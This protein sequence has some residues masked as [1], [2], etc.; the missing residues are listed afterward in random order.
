MVECLQQRL[1]DHSHI[2]DHAVHRCNRKRKAISR[3]EDWFLVFLHILAI[4]KGESLHN[5]H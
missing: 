2:A 1:W 5:N 4:G 3:I